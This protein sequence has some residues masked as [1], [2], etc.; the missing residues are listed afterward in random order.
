MPSGI[1][2]THSPPVPAFSGVLGGLPVVPVQGT[3]LPFGINLATRVFTHM[4]Q[5]VTA[6]LL[7][8][9]VQFWMYL[10]DWLFM[11]PSEAEAQALFQRTLWIGKD[12]GLIF[13]FL[14]SRLQ[15]EMQLQ[16]L[17]LLWDMG[18][19]TVSLFLVNR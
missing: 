4:M 10:D 11:G 16:F 13:Y 7:Q 3:V 15:P 17:G 18:T 5:P 8:A 12:M 6:S 9:G 14:K 1:L 19:A 2:C